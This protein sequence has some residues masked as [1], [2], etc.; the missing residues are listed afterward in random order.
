MFKLVNS[1]TKTI[2]KELAEQFRSMPA[3]PTERD[4]N[5]ARMNY[6]RDKFTTGL[7]I[8]F[9]WATAKLGDQ[10][11]RMNGQHSSKILAEW[12][13]ADFPQNFIVHLDQYEVTDDNGL[14]LLFRQFDDRKSGRSPADVAGAYQGL[15][16]PLREVPKGSAKLAVE[17]IGWWR[18]HVEGLPVPNGDSI[19]SLMAETGLHPFI[20]WVGEVFTIKTPELKRVPVVAAMYATFIGAEEDARKFWS[21]VARGGVEYDDNHP[22]TVLDAWLKAIKEGD[23]AAEKHKPADFYQGCV[24]AWNAF[25]DDKPLKDIKSD[26]KKGLHTVKA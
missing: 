17:G 14:A 16:P 13:G 3:S 18:R 2:T 20:Q 1:E 9:N 11:V 26:L 8:T 25:F 6:L 7:A 12:E 23:R 5:T 15:Y 21:E 22:T 19:Y 10:V 4:L 24:Y